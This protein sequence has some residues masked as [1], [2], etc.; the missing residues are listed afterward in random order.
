MLE[1]DPA[2]RKEV[3]DNIRWAYNARNDIAHG[4]NPV[5]SIRHFSPQTTPLICPDKIF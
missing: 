4:D 3:G 5:T 2:R 1:T